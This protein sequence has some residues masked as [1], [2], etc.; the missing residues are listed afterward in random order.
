MLGQGEGCGVQQEL[1]PFQNCYSYFVSGI[2]WEDTLLLKYLS[3]IYAALNENVLV[4][5]VVCYYS[6]SSINANYSLNPLY[7]L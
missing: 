6:A 2:C 5:L 4:F 7:I 3:K 1:G